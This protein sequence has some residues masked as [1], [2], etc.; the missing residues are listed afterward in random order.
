MEAYIKTLLDYDGNIV[1]PSTKTE[2]IYND[3]GVA[4]EEVLNQFANIET[5]NNLKGSIVAATMTASNWNSSA[6]TYSFESTYPNATYD[7]DI[8]INGDSCTAAQLDAWSGAKIVGSASSNVAKAFGDVPTVNI[9]IIL[10][11]T[12]K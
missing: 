11:I 3:E 10:T 8:E 5:V 4:L 9:P 6:K 12:K 1:Y 2:A 7:L